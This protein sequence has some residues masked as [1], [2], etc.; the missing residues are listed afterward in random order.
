MGYRTYL[1]EISKEEHDQMQVMSYTYLCKKY[2]DVPD[3]DPE[4]MTVG[5]YELVKEIYGFGKY[6][7]M[8][9]SLKTPFFSDKKMQ[10]MF[11][12][13][14][15]FWVVTKDFLEKVIEQERKATEEFYTKSATEYTEEQLRHH[16]ISTAKEWGADGSFVDSPYELDLQ[17][18][19]LV[20]SWRREYQIFDLVRIY[21]TFDFEKNHLIYYGW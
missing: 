18:P 16:F 6:Y 3:S 10:E 20:T 15:D 2:G 7:D 9:E 5:V 4:Y 12:G 8:P 1:G 13:D 11:D 19:E 14:S 17:K 21:K